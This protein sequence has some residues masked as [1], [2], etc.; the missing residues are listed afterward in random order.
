MTDET[1]IPP[2]G[3]NDTLPEDADEL[4][5]SAWNSPDARGLD[6]DAALAAVAALSEPVTEQEAEE[7]AQDAAPR[8]RI[9]AYT[10]TLPLPPLTRLRRGQPGSVIP[11][12]FLIGIGGWLT[13]TTTSGGQI[14]GMLLAVAV[15]GGVA[16]SLLAHWIGSGRWS[17]GTLLFGA[18]IVL[19]AGVI[20]AAGRVPVSYPALVAAGGVALILGG[21]LA[22]PPVRRVTAPGLLLIAAGGVGWL[23]TLEIVPPSLLPLAA[24]A[25]PG[26]AVI[27]LIVLLLPRLRRR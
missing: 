24:T 8:K 2:Q 15:I 14:D 4:S 12:L 27:V 10:P 13:L 5:A 23:V 7:I 16:L 18:L 25:A 6:I 20:F 3:D 26:V 17:R 9:G 1:T 11:A 19:A 22:R 21:R